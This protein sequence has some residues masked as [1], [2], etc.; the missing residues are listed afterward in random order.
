MDSASETSATFPA[1]SGWDPGRP[2]NHQ[3][4]WADLQVSELLCPRLSSEDGSVF[5]QGH[6]E[7]SRTLMG[8]KHLEDLGHTFLLAPYDLSHPW[9]VSAMAV[10]TYSTSHRKE[11]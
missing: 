11:L 2:S 9:R 7:L 5:L 4:T 10:I 1:G 6:G 3:V 8:K